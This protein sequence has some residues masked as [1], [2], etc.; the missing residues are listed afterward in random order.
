MFVVVCGANLV[1]IVALMTPQLVVSVRVAGIFF[2]GT[3]GCLRVAG[4]RGLADDFLHEA[5]EVGRS[6]A[7]AGTEVAVKRHSEMAITKPFFIFTPTRLLLAVL[8]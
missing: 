1:N 7:C 3:F 2:A 6:A 5:T 8:R 4:T